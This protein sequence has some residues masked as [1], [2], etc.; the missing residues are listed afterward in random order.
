MS[1]AFSGAK[2]HQSS[3][4]RGDRIGPEVRENGQGLYLG[5]EHRV[6]R[7]SAEDLEIVT[8]NAIM[9]RL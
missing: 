7:G 4:I 2:T 1:T 6:A 9:E 3:L 5:L 8:W